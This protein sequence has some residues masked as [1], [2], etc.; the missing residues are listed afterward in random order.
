MNGISHLLEHMLYRG[1]PGYPTAHQQALAFES[2][3][4]TLSAATG[5]D[6]GSLTVGCPE[7]NFEKILPLLSLV[8]REP[9]LSGLEVEKRIIREEILEDLDES[10]ELIDDYALLRRAAFDGHALGFPVTGTAD[11]L[12]RL[13]EADLRR[14]HAAHYVGGATVVSIAGSVDPDRVIRCVEAHFGVVSPGTAPAVVAPSAPSGPK[15]VFVDS[16]SSQ[17]AICVGFRAA[18]YDSPTHLATDV[19]VRLLDDGNSTRLYARLGD[20]LGLVYDVAAGYD[21]A[22][23]AGLLDVGC[24]A[25]HREAPRILTEILAEVTRLRDDGPDEA[26]LQR[27][28]DR[29]RWGLLEMLDSPGSVA[30]FFADATR[31]GTI[32]SLEERREAID[33][34][35]VETARATADALFR[36]R[37]M[38][39]VLV[40]PKSRATRNRFSDAIRKF[41]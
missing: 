35:T 36:P 24:D 25:V 15:T 13:T 41:V 34:V 10:G 31:R 1:I 38:T 22:E 28:K 7:E 23:E 40:G 19:L 26:E 17:S 9:L 4:G 12:D 39:A 6:T 21:V 11:K 33:G 20:E 37:N 18:G 27:V 2:L 14:H 5:P 30:E 3:G 32:K 29:H 8:Y 16:A